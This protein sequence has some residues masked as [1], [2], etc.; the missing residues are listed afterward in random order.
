MEDNT[1]SVNIGDLDRSPQFLQ[2]INCI[3]IAEFHDACLCSSFYTY[4][5]IFT[6]ISIFVS[7]DHFINLV[8]VCVGVSW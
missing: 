1:L 3:Y 7:G 6:N 2:L 5:Y 4:L 8:Y